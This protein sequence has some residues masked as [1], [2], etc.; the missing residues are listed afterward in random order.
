MSTTRRG[1][2]G[3]AAA[4]VMAPLIKLRPEIERES[5]LREFCC[6]HSVR[7]DLS[8]P[9]GIG[10]MTYG[11]DGRRAVRVELT[12][13]DEDGAGRR[14]DMETIFAAAWHPDRWREFVLPQPEDLTLSAGLEICPH[15]L[16]RRV[17]SGID[18]KDMQWRP[19]GEPDLPR[20]MQGLDWDVDDN[21]IR[22]A[23]CVVCNG[24]RWRGPDC[25]LIDELPFSY[26]V[27][28]PLSRLSSVKV[29][30]SEAYGGCLLFAGD[31][32]EGVVLSLKPGA[33][34]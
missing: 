1:F 19:D 34:R 5:I 9:F 13:R 6:Q 17:P 16:N 15:C 12:A 11:T 10:S 24:R 14:P 25:L 26:E 29:A 31:G 23:S 4:L 20:H 3:A 21:T 32:F 22:D 7:Y 27:L 33:L 30:M 18:W 28:A 8:T 2:M